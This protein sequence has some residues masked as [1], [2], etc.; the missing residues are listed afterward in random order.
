MFKAWDIYQ[1]LYYLY[2]G[3]TL[4]TDMQKVKTFPQAD[5]GGLHFPPQSV[6]F[7][8]KSKNT[9]KETSFAMN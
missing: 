1:D 5:F 6:E 9:V 4:P 7:R 2:V 3:F 8:K